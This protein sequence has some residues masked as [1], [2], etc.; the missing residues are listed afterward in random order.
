MVGEIRDRSTAST[1]LKAAETGHLVISAIHTPDTVST[2]QRYIGMFESDSQDIV[3]E[4]LGDALQAIISLR[5]IPAKDG[6]RLPVVEIL[7]VTRTIRESIR[8][9]KLNDIPEQ[10]RK[11]RDLYNM[12]LF[13]QHLLDMTNAGLISICLLYTS[14]SPRDATLSRMPSSA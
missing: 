5:L 14:P 12:Q 3:R 11:G 8:L 2:I 7:R 9:N 4:R 10:I 6:R 1:C 13:D